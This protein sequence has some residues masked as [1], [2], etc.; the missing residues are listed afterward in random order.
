MHHLI[1]VNVPQLDTLPYSHWRSIPIIINSLISQTYL[2]LRPQEKGVEWIDWEPWQKQCLC[3][4]PSA[5]SSVS[6]TTAESLLWQFSS[7]PL[8]RGT[9][10]SPVHYACPRRPNWNWKCYDPLC[11]TPNR[12]TLETR[13]VRQLQTSHKRG[14]I[15]KSRVGRV[16]GRDSVCAHTGRFSGLAKSGVGM[17]WSLTDSLIIDVVFGSTFMFFTL[18]SGYG[19]AA[20]LDQ[21]THCA[22]LAELWGFPSE[23]TGHRV[24]A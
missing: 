5:E 17:R 19:S 3:L 16:G 21:T 9:R 1:W 6:S 2:Y 4:R 11:C 20:P 23:T 10:A 18:L 15:L 8:Q 14:W 22:S 7:S 13:L 24:R 12:Q